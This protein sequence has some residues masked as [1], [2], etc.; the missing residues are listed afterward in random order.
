MFIGNSCITDLKRDDGSYVCP[1]D[2]TPFAANQVFP[3][4]FMK[5][6]VLNLVVACP[7]SSDD[8]MWRGEVRHIDKGRVVQLQLPRTCKKIGPFSDTWNRNARIAYN[9]APYAETP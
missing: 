9:C 4:N 3:D 2:K 7:N 8:C 1:V 5:R 6:E